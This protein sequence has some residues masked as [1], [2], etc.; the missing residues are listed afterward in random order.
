MLGKQEE[1]GQNKNHSN[2]ILKVGSVSDL[3][4]HASTS[5]LVKLNELFIAPCSSEVNLDLF[6]I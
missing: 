6:V 5:K 2:L 1:L 4:L 3:R